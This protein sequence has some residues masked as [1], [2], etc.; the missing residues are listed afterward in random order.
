MATPAT[1]VDDLSGIFSGRLLLMASL[2][3][4]CKA[5]L[6]LNTNLAHRHQ[7][8]LQGVSVYLFGLCRERPD[9]RI[10]AYIKLPRTFTPCLLNTVKNWLAL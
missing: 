3:G 9:Q 7:P 1:A 8:L 4:L 6:P 2:T 10:K 5:V